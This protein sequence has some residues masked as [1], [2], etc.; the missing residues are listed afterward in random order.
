MPCIDCE[1]ADSNGRQ[2]KF[3]Q[4]RAHPHNDNS[5]PHIHVQTVLSFLIHT[6]NTFRFLLDQRLARNQMKDD[7]SIKQPPP[8]SADYQLF[9]IQS[10]INLIYIS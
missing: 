3:K 9:Q 5:M 6:L 4:K 2:F 1:R 10:S 7:L 8:L